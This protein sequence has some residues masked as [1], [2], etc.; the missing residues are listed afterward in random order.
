MIDLNKFLHDLEF[1]DG[2]WQS[3]KLGKISYPE[4][5]NNLYYNIEDQ[6]YWFKNRNKII[7]EVIKK[8]SIDGPIFDVGGGNG[9]VVNYLINNG[10]ETVLVEPG[11]DGCMNGKERG[12]KYIINSFF[13][14]THFYPNSIPNI[15][16]FD[17]LEHI[18]NPSDF[19][20]TLNAITDS[21]WQ[22]IHHGTC[23]FLSLVRRR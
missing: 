2:I 21:E 7:F 1:Q 10:F 4:S 8:F 11:I 23:L 15:G 19:L 3:Q 6:S 12:L 14:K 5:G 20:K 17:V 13:D 22:N 16:L 18:E 9:F